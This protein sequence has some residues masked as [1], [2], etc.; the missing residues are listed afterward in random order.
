MVDRIGRGGSL[1]QEAIQAALRRQEAARALVD[2]SAA[3]VSRAAGDVSGASSSRAGGAR[4]TPSSFVQA[5]REGAEEV[6]QSVQAADELPRAIV[7]GR[8]ADFH[9]IAAQIKQADLS[10]K[11]ALE[12]RNK[13]IDAYREVMRMSV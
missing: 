12:V 11:F 4:E 10:F 5:L 13:L 3:D 9:E 1:A 2:Q 8:V 6:V 7:D